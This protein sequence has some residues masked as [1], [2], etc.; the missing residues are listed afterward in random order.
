MRFRRALREKR[1]LFRDFE[2]PPPFRSTK[3]IL[4]LKAERVVDQY[5]KISFNNLEY[6]LE[7]VS[8]RNRVQLRI[9]PDVGHG[10]AEIRFWY[11]DRFLGI[12]KSGQ[13]A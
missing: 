6:K 9:V 8:A 12:R 4:S 13:T 11:E 7:G 5:R 3:D 1:T 2:V 10:M